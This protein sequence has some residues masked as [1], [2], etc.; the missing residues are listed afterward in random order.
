[1]AV[2]TGGREAITRW[3]VIE[4]Y[5][6]DDAETVASALR[7]ELETGRTHQIRVHLSHTGHPL[8]GDA[9]YGSHFKTKA[10]RLNATAQALLAGLRRQA[11]HAAHLTIE[12]PLT[13]DVMSFDADWPDD[14]A[15]LAQALRG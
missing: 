4:R 14:M 15:H 9:V 6:G 8:L 11:L 10:S 7:C 2:R 3:Q 1:M 12:H 13:G 5:S